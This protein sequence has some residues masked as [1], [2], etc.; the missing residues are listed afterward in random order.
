LRLNGFANWDMTSNMFTIWPLERI[1][2]EY[3]RESDKSFIVFADWL[4]NSHHIGFVKGKNGVFKMYDMSPVFIAGSFS[5]VVS[6][7]NED[8]D[9]LY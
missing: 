8:A 1:V 2:E 5:E 3:N 9:I 6:L 7:I 4:I